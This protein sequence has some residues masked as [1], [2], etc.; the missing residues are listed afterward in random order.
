MKVG[1]DEPRFDY[2]QR[3]G[4]VWLTDSDEKNAIKYDAEGIKYGR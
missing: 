2:K 3:A 1:K 4:H